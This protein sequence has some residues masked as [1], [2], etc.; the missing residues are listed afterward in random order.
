MM[1]SKLTA[2]KIFCHASETAG[3]QLNESAINVGADGMIPEAE[4]WLEVY[5]CGVARV[6]SCLSMQRATAPNSK[7]RSSTPR[8]GSVSQA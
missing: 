2:H 8:L 7:L 5:V 3:V 1:L 4:T 6:A